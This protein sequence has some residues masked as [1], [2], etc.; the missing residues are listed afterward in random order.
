LQDGDC[1]RCRV[2][3]EL[4]GD[5]IVQLQDN[6]NRMSLT[7]RKNERDNA[8]YI[9]EIEGL[10]RDTEISFLQTVTALSNAIEAKDPYT[11]GHSERVAEFCEKVAEA[12][13]LGDPERKELRFAAI[14]HDVGKI[15]IDR[16][17]LRKN[18]GLSDGEEFQIRSHPE[19]GVQIL[20]PVRF[21]RPVLPT[22]RHHHERFDG[23]GYPFG[24][25]GKDI[26]LNARIVCIADAWDAMRSDRPYRNALPV[27]RAVEELKEN[28]GTQFDPEIVEVILTHF[29]ASHE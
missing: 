12:M 1:R 19:W 22:I 10:N 29:S 4:K 20:E 7:L 25:K 15:G 3:R 9:R 23:S 8:A 21:L 17:L 13:N 26:P 16:D 2:Y 24:L 18:S 11:R 5:E 27:E 28:A 6:F 14:L